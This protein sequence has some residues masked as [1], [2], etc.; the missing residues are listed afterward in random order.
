MRLLGPGDALQSV[1][2]A[3]EGLLY[4]STG[5]QA[6]LAEAVTDETIA[7]SFLTVV[8]MRTIATPIDSM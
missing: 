8:E 1:S 7:E 4:G 3:E 6:L 5:A 2:F